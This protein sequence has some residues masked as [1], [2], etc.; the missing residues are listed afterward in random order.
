MKKQKDAIYVAVTN[1]LSDN[2]VHFEDGMNASELLTKEFRQSVHGIIAEGFT[3]NDIEFADTPA[4]QAKLADE[5]KLSSYVSGLISNW[6]RKDTR[7]NGGVVYQPKNPGSRIGSTDPQ[8]KALRGLLK[9]FEGTNADKAAKIQEQI[10][11][12]VSEIQVD[13]AKKVDIDYSA[14][15]EGLAFELGLSEE[16]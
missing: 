8:L 1:V 13:R 7:L 10:D 6:L 4:N 2:G 16:A 5:T 11:A 15:P 14:L 3:S 9:Q 12:R